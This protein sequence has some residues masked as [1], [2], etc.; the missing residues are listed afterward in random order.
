M[1]R[2]FQVGVPP[3]REPVATPDVSSRSGDARPEEPGEDPF[4]DL[5]KTRPCRWFVVEGRCQFGDGCMHA[6]S[7]GELRPLPERHRAPEAA[8]WQGRAVC[9]G[10]IDQAL[11]HGA[12]GPRTTSIP[13]STSA[14]AS[15]AWAIRSPAG[16]TRPA[17][18][19]P[20]ATP[21]VGASRS[22]RT[23]AR[24]LTST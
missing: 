8:H 18:S 13:C 11:F 17:S 12:P 10:L 6:H 22:T 15:R 9:I 2:R 16:A 5:W 7:A 21:T 24:P 23:C 3:P 19:R 1:H 20:R 4:K 14:T